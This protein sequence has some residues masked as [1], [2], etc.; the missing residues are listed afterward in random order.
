[1]KKSKLMDGKPLTHTSTERGLSE[2]HG[3]GMW[4]SE[5]GMVANLLASRYH[6]V[7]YKQGYELTRHEIVVLT[8]KR[9]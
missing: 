1:M 5:T 7:I 6:K 4:D 8:P 9:R 2:A 3:N